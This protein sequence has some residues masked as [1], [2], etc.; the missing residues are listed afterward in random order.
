MITGFGNH[1]SAIRM[2]YENGGTTLAIEHGSRRCD[3]TNQRYSRV[4]VVT[5]D[6]MIPPPAQ[7]F[8]S[9]R[10]GSTVKNVGG[11]HAIYVSN[12]QAVADIIEEAATRSSKAE[13]QTS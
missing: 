2:T 3:V 13:A 5:E 1:N 4:L 8:M 12:P 11:S 6:R 9:Q 10:A 7:Q